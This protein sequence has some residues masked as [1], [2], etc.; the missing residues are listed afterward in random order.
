MEE[1]KVLVRDLEPVVKSWL[2]NVFG[3]D[4]GG[5]QPVYLVL[6]RTKLQPG[7]P[8]WH[9]AWADVERFLDETNA[10]LKDVSNEEFEAAVEEAIQAVRSRPNP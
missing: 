5:D 10:S 3:Q 8:E 1:R 4:L 9:E 2:N 6:P 7:S